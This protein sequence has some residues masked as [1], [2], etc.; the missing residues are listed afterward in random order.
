MQLRAALRVGFVW[1]FFQYQQ[2]LVIFWGFPHVEGAATIDEHSLQ[3]NNVHECKNNCT[4][5]GINHATT[6]WNKVFNRFVCSFYSSL[7]FAFCFTAN[8]QSRQMMMMPD[9]SPD[10]LKE[11][12]IALRSQQA[13]IAAARAIPTYGA[14]SDKG[15]KQQV[16]WRRYRNSSPMY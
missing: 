3:I 10:L 9:A 1:F 5:A 8:C 4:L 11:G 12:K 15:T 7:T 16:L 6:W 13:I 2:I 14:W